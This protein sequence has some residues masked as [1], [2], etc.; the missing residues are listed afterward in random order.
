M[1]LLS[2]LI[3]SLSFEVGYHYMMFH[4]LNRISDVNVKVRKAIDVAIDR[5]A[6][7]QALA[8]GKA[9]RSLFPDYS[10]FQ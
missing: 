5:I 4:N 9:T 8:G 1:F 2:H 3:L 7:S 10:Q 6:L